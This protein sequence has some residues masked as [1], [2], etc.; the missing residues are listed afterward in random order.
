MTAPSVNLD[1]LA[2]LFSE[3][4]DVFE[5]RDDETRDDAGGGDLG[6]GGQVADDKTSPIQG[7]GKL[8]EEPSASKIFK[9]IDREV[10]RQERLAKNRDQIGL[11]WDRIKKGVQFSILEKSEDQNYYRAVLPPG[12]EDIEQPIPN[13]VLDLC[14]KQVSQILVDP[15]LPNPKPD[16][17]SEKNRGAMD[18]AKRFLRADGDSS[19]TNDMQLFRQALTYNRTRA[20][21]FIYVWVDPTAGGW[22]PKQKKAHPQAT[23]PKRPLFGPKLDGNNQ[24]LLDESGAPLMIE[25]TTDPVLRYVGQLEVTNPETGE[26]TTKEGFVENAAEADREWLP[27]HRAKILT[28]NQVRT[29]PA[30]ATAFEA[31]SIILL[32]WEPL[33]EAKKRFPVLE[34]LDASSLK[35]L[36]TWKPKRWKAIVPQAHRPKSDGLD[37]DGTV[38]DD[39]L[40]FWYHKFCRI[41]PGYPDGAEIAVNGASKVGQDAEPGFVLLRDTLREDVEVDDGTTVPV[42][43][44]PPIAQFTAL[45]D[46][47]DG[48]DPQGIAPVSAFGGANEIRA[49]LYVAVLEDIDVRLHPNTFLGSTSPVTK[50]EINRRDGTPID[51]TTK[52]DMPV[53]EQRPE[54]PAHTETMLNRIEHDMDTAANLSQTAQALD[55]KYAVSGEAKKVSI[56]QAKVQLA[57]DWQ[58]FNNGCNQFW[59]IKLQLAQARLK[60]P[61]LVKLA[62]Q[63]AAYKSRHFVGADLIGVSSV[64]TQSGSGT[65][66][67]PSEKAQYIATFQSQKWLEV[68]QASELARSSMSDDLG[69]EPTA[70][71]EHIDRCIADW[72]DGPPEGWEEQYQAFAEFPQQQQAHVATLE[73]AVAT[74]TSGGGDPAQA[75][76]LATEN[77][78]PAPTP[79]PEPWTP[80]EARANDEEP[81]VAKIRYQKLS[82]LMSTTEYNEQPKSWRTCVDKAYEQA[83]YAAGIVTVRQQAEAAAKAQ[84]AAAAD[85][86]NAPPTWKEF[87]AKV[88]QTAVAAAAAEVAKVVEG[89]NGI[90]QKPVEAKVEKPEPADTTHLELAHASM[91]SERDRQHEL[92]MAREGHA[93]TMAQTAEQTKAD[94]VGK[95]LDHTAQQS[96]EAQLA[97]RP[98]HSTPR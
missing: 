45:F 89:L 51:I 80:F 8:L 12:V 5:Q 87:L 61:M 86:A 97:P 24:P 26:V 4:D 76:Q 43:M 34:T 3:G 2:K 33:G 17:D 96:R 95:Q 28:A 53:F 71:E 85:D 64:A 94:L 25:R 81:V 78:P 83:A 32:M 22:R 10:L 98:I 60:T 39:T 11:H 62:G 68:E 15:P 74:L 70:H 7:G 58:G 13:K 55:S 41:A 46:D 66:M 59:K 82:K 6:A 18:L 29:L 91:E 93:Q 77:G 14:N 54:L 63:N 23:D 88:T 92:N 47:A 30:T 79:P 56:H 84:G 20:S 52:D 48:G 65:M 73:K 49:H 37:G 38:T 75:Q 72:I 69:L 1:P 27:K 36:T 16:G 35:Q 9:T 19:G 67:S 42:L 57:Q 40:L 90:N 44:E 50:D 31:H 21:S